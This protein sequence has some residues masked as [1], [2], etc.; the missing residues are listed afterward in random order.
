MAMPNNQ[1]EDLN[2]PKEEADHEQ[3]SSPEEENQNK[4]DVLSHAD[5]YQGAIFKYQPKLFGRD[6]GE[7]V[8]HCSLSMHMLCIHLIYICNA[9]H[10]SQ[11]GWVRHTSMHMNFV[12]E[13]C[14]ARMVPLVNMTSVHSRQYVHWGPIPNHW[15]GSSSH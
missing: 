4:V 14:P 13:Q 7:F 11:V 15:V 2:V 10:T 3:P 5:I 8:Q 6:Q 9:L 1:G 12:L